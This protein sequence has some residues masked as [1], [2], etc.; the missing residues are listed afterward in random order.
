MY[1]VVTI[2]H[3]SRPLNSR[4]PANIGL[5]RRH[6]LI[7]IFPGASGERRNRNLPRSKKSEGR[8]KMLTLLTFRW[9]KN[10][11]VYAGLT[12][13][14]LFSRVRRGKGRSWHVYLY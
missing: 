10:L 11:N 6:D 9:M 8:W 3:L 13:Q 2:L 4:T 1:Q 7:S 14:G 12:F 5:S